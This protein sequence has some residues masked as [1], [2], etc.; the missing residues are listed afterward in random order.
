[1]LLL[2]LRAILSSI[3]SHRSL[4]LQNLALRHQLEVLQRNAKKPRLSNRDRVLWIALSRLWPDWQ[5]PLSI[6]QPKTVVAWHRR[7]WR[8]HWRWKSRGRGRPVVSAEV[9]HLI[10]R[11]SRENPLWGAPRVHGELLKLGYE[12]SE[13]T[14][15]KYMVK[16]R[17]S[18][19]CSSLQRDRLTHRGMDKP[20]ARSGIPVRH[21]PE[22]L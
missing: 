12:F 5:E 13:A 4:T 17:R 2:I 18:A 8:L 14:V 1:M 21:R 16:H 3:K 11:M 9:R 7:G 10:R 15:A 19:S 22:S 20:A 6:V